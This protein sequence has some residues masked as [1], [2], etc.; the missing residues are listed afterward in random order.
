MDEKINNENNSFERV[1]DHFLK[2]VLEITVFFERSNCLI[3]VVF[4]FDKPLSE[5]FSILVVQHPAFRVH[6]NLER[7]GCFHEEIQREI[8]RL[9][10]MILF[11]KRVSGTLE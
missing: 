8:L 1:F 4:V 9:V 11:Q 5:P 3:N 10:R 7:N 6:E 2:D